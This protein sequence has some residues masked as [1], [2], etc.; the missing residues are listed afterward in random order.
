[1]GLTV[2]PLW[3]RR[4][5]ALAGPGGPGLQHL[6]HCCPFRAC[7]LSL[8]LKVLTCG[9]HSAPTKTSPRL[10]LVAL[11]EDPDRNAY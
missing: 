1:M 2:E 10:F 6:T 4:G 8:R 3:S 9:S 7:P 11:T 5:G